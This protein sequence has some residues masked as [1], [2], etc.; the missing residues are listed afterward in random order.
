VGRKTSKSAA[1]KLAIGAMLMGFAAPAAEAETLRGELQRFLHD[2][3]P[4]RVDGL[5]EPVM[6]SPARRRAVRQAT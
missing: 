3:S 2:D 5:P 1:A 4:S 6:A